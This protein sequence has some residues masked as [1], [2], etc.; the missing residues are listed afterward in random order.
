MRPTIVYAQGDANICEI[1][2]QALED[3][4]YAVVCVG[5]G[6]AALTAAREEGV[7]LLVVDAV[8]PRRD[9]YEVIEQLRSGE[10][11][12]RGIPAVLLYAGRVGDPSR[13][14]VDALGDVALLGKPV[15]LDRLVGEVGA[16]VKQTASG[17]ASDGATRPAPAHAGSLRDVHFGALLH[18]LH[19]ARASGVL[20]VENGKKKKAIQLRDGY[21]VA[22][23]SNLVT[24]CLGNMLSRRGKLSQDALDE[25]LRRVKQGEGLQGEILVAMEAVDEETVAEALREQAEAKLL[26]IFEW[27]RGRY[28]FEM[29]KKL[30][31]AATLSLTDSPATLIWEGARRHVT[32]RRVDDFIAQHGA[33]YLTPADSPFHRFQSVDVTDEES[34]LIAE[35]DPSRPLSDYLDAPERVRRTLYALALTEILELSPKRAARDRAPRRVTREPQSTSPQGND[36]SLR[37]ELT[38]LARELRG[39]NHYEVLGLPTIADDDAVREAYEQ[40]IERVHPDRYR[41]SSGAVRQ[42]ADEIYRLFTSAYDALRDPEARAEY[43]GELKRDL[44]SQRDQVRSRKILSAETTFQRGEAALKQRDYEGAL[45]FFGS[46]LEQMPEEGLYH[47]HYGWSLHLCHPD[48]EVIVQE[49]IEHIQE[50]VRLARDHETPYL[51]LG[52][53]YKVVGRTAAAEKMFTRAVQLRSDC[54]EALRELRLLNMRRD[55]GRGLLGRMLKRG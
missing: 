40:Q 9:G 48:N 32:I 30:Q 42:V 44:A 10:G 45:V 52:R 8:L 24:E 31:R 55:K 54:V 2:R 46:A 49:A 11:P 12:T 20:L 19:D 13:R 43:A 28:R 23:K 18:A 29:R 27:R 17:G 36:A 1:H 53:L 14:R 41:S 33:V 3:A 22:V 37:H 7:D 25:S 50:G 38:V 51:F 34:A 15:P 16:L 21:P 26:E 35:L 6:D 4:G 5:D 47:A 39:K